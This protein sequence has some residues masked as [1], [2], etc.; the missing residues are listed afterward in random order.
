MA[1]IAENSAH[2]VTEVAEAFRPPLVEEWKSIRADFAEA[3]KTALGDDDRGRLFPEIAVSETKR[4]R[5]QA[6]NPMEALL[7]DHAHDQARD[8]KLGAAA[9]EKSIEH[10]LED[11]AIRGARQMEEHYHR[12]RS[13]DA[14]RLRN[15]LAAAITSGELA[16]LASGLASGARHRALT[17]K[18]DRSGLDE[19]VA[20]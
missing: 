4:L 12:E 5:A 17:A 20:L 6:S 19:G 7:A 3:V 1:K 14:G 8:A 18:A 15:H 16:Q 9:Y 10:F 13:P 2:T 11:R